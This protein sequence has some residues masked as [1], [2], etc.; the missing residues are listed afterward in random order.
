MSS[1]TKNSDN[2][3]DL[4]ATGEVVSER[5]RTYVANMT[6][7][8]DM[9]IADLQEQNNHLRE[10]T[11]VQLLEE[12]KQLE[13]RLRDSERENARLQSKLSS[14]EAIELEQYGILEF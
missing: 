8:D 2:D 13:Q 11:L 9:T 6:A 12:Q 4:A 1:M 10:H 5:I 3:R 14:A 7:T